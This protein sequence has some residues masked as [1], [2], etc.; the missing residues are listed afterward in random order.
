MTGARDLSASLEQ[1][2]A[3]ERAGPQERGLS[4]AIANLTFAKIGILIWRRLWLAGCCLIGVLV[5]T[6]LLIASI[7]PKYTARTT[8]II[9]PG[10]IRTFDISGQAR[11]QD[12]GNSALQSQ[13]ELIKSDETTQRVARMIRPVGGVNIPSPGALRHGLSAARRGLSYLIDITY[14]ARHALDAQT[15]ANAYADAY[16]KGMLDNRAKTA[17]QAVDLLETEIDRVRRKLSAAER[18]VEAFKASN[19]LI[20]AYGGLLSERQISDISHQLTLARVRRA[21]MAARVEQIDRGVIPDDHL[22][23]HNGQIEVQD[24]QNSSLI[25]QLRSLFVRVEKDAADLQRRYRPNH[26]KVVGILAQ[27]R[28][29]AREISQEVDRIYAKVRNEADVARAREEALA[30][31]LEQAKEQSKAMSQAAVQ[32]KELERQVETTKALYTSMLT[33]QNELVAQLKLN[34]IDARIVSRANLPESPSAPRPRRMMAAAGLLGL[35][36]GLVAA[37]M[38]GLLFPP[39]DASGGL[40]ASINKRVKRLQHLFA[41]N[42]EPEPVKSRKPPAPERGSPADAVRSA[43]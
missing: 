38:S 20:N 37:L 11:D 36:L 15:L 8:L 18:R 30:A 41:T 7:V 27:K 5:L 2:L 24:V 26:P 23:A 4:S 35:V 16:I 22:I 42:L 31:G 3:N 34:A 12:T 9:E 19:G 21:E 28:E 6:Q 32:L 25:V 43:G 39:G 40:V 13:V 33:K 14:T 29:I 1:A 10:Q 17:R